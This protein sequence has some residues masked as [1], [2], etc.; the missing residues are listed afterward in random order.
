MKCNPVFC[1][2]LI[3][4]FFSFDSFG[5]MKPSTQ[6]YLPV[7]TA[8]P[9]ESV[10]VDV[11][12]VDFRNIAGLTM[13]VRWDT[14]ALQLET[15]NSPELPIQAN[16]IN[17]PS[18]D[19]GLLLLSWTSVPAAN[20]PDSSTFLQLCFLI[21]D[22]ADSKYAFIAFDDRRLAHDVITDEAP[23]ENPYI[24][25][26]FHPGGLIIQPSNNDLTLSAVVEAYAVCEE[27]ITS[28]DLSLSGGLPPYQIEW[29]GPS[30]F[31]SAEEDLVSP[32]EGEY[33]LSVT[34]DRGRRLKGRFFINIIENESE[35]PSLIVD[36]NITPTDCRRQE[37]AIALSMTTDP[38]AYTYRWSNGDT[39]AAINH[40]SSGHYTVTVTDMRGCVD[41]QSFSVAGFGNIPYEIIEYDSIACDNPSVEIGVRLENPDLFSYSWNTGADQPIIS[42]ESR[43]NYRLVINNGE[44][45]WEDVRIPVWENTARSRTQRFAAALS[46]E[47]GTA[48]IG[49]PDLN[50]DEYIFSWTHERFESTTEVEEPGSYVLEYLAVSEEDRCSYTA[51]F[52]VSEGSFEW[53]RSRLEQNLRCD[54]PSVAIGFDSIQQ[55]ELNFFWPNGG[56]EPLTYVENPGNYEVTISKGEFCAETADFSVGVD[57]FSFELETIEEHLGC[58]SPVA[59]IGV[60]LPAD[61]AGYFFFWPHSEE[62]KPQVSVDR[63]G[64]YTL[65][66][67]KG[68]CEE[69][70]RL[71]VNAFDAPLEVE[72][73]DLNYSCEDTIKTIGAATPDTARYNYRWES[74]ERTP[75]IDVVQTGRYRL[76]VTENPYC[77]AR[78]M[79]N[80]NPNQ[81][82]NYNLQFET[83]N[84]LNPSATIGVL[85]LDSIPYRYRWDNGDTTALTEAATPGWNR[86]EIARGN[87]CFKEENLWVNSFSQ[88]WLFSPIQ[89]NLSCFDSLATIGVTYPDTLDLDFSWNTG[90]T[91]NLLA[92]DAAGQYRLMIDG[93]PGCRETFSFEVDPFDRGLR[94]RRIEEPLRCEESI[95]AVGVEMLD[96]D[97][98]QY[99]WSTGEDVS[100]LTITESGLYELTITNLTN[101]C[102]TQTSFEIGSPVLNAPEIY[103]ECLEENIC[104]AITIKVNAADAQPPVVYAWST[105][106]IDTAGQSAQLTLGRR[107]PVDLK[108]MDAAGCS[109]DLQNISPVCPEDDSEDLQ[110]RLYLNCEPEGARSVDPFLYAEVLSGGIPPYHFEWNTGFRDT[111][112][113]LSSLPYDENQGDYYVTVTDGLGE[114]AWWFVRRTELYGCGEEN[115]TVH[116]AAPHILVAPG[117]RF[118]YPIQVYDYENLARAV[119]TIDWD[120]CLLQVDSIVQ[121]Y[122]ER[123]RFPHPPNQSTSEVG[124]VDLDTLDLPDTVTVMKI[125]Y[126]AV[127]GAEGV[128]PFLFSINEPGSYRDGST[129]FLRPHHGSITVAR[130]QALVLPGDT[131]ADRAVNH[132]DLLNLGLFYNG[133]GPDRRLGQTKREEYAF[134]WRQK[135]PLSNVNLK[136]LDCNGDGFIN[137]LDTVVIAQNW[138]LNSLVEESLIEASGPDL[139]V[140]TDTILPGMKQDFPIFLGEETTTS[141]SAYGLAF[142]IDYDDQVLTPESVRADFVNSWFK[143]NSASAPLIISR[144]DPERSQIHLAIVRADQTNIGGFGEVARLHFTARS[145]IEKPEAGFSMEN[146]R[147]INAA[148]EILPVNSLSAFA[149]VDGLT[150]I[151]AIPFDSFISLYPSPAADWL[152]I[153]HPKNLLLQRAEI[154]DLNGRL[155][156]QTRN[157]RN[158]QL[159]VSSLPP[160]AYVL[161]L[162]TNKG[163]T[164]KRWIKAAFD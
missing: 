54:R 81:H 82:L 5:Q 110:L 157:L 122:P 124:F 85:P 46:C 79:I 159:D 23:A 77:S 45:C 133:G 127:E 149:P 55:E 76:T 83:I 4:L 99:E 161:R 102:Q 142:T 60:Q 71:A 156:I 3:C 145:S 27:K 40:L 61:T 135:T 107:Y 119:F 120:N 106:Q 136:H 51:K 78:L 143:E 138:D 125:Y 63:T 65:E 96:T 10:C 29:S 80:L 44:N 8:L 154:F 35:G 41:N 53:N 95:G 69:S 14:T 62:N 20:L 108:I 103:F 84:C 26:R 70:Y 91:T 33:L 9:G 100:Q 148:E 2:F 105:D 146:V 134:P 147:L 160:G 21:A 86:L 151:Q 92:V 28:V 118:V 123:Y 137:A 39:T 68:A 34:D 42:V 19:P 17:L 155:I 6:F 57:P 50:P 25:A 126:Q 66:I 52:E 37:G 12:V 101:Q 90:D 31:S 128:S 47:T 64:T 152:R 13:G 49:L 48:T 36:A 140:Q 150:S 16:N 56:T 116:F 104:G 111:S 93:G 162:T 139:W 73:L 94:F 74:G 18:D 43:G 67:S 130:Q 144:N 114:S 38:A 88:R 112:H 7:E 98:Y 89:E 131:D 58:G 1:A 87:F 109:A 32:E 22:N 75:T 153:R 164:A 15:Y 24:D 30:G 97:L 141:E 72:L 11:R 158:R 163:A 129:A 121:L 115:N 132:I 117:D 113:F 59:N